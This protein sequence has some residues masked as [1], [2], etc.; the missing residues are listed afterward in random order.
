VFVSFSGLLGPLAFA[1]EEVSD[2][3]KLI[4]SLLDYEN[5]RITDISPDR[6]SF[7]HEHGIASLPIEKVPA[8]IRQQ[9]GLTADDAK[10]Y[11]E[12]I[13]ESER[14]RL[15]RQKIENL[16]K[17]NAVEFRGEIFQILENGVFLKDVSYTD[18]S[19][20]EK[21]ENYQVQTGG[22]NALN[23]N[24]S[25][26]FGTRERRSWETKVTTIR[27]WPIHVRTRSMP[28]IDGNVFSAIVYPIGTFTYETRAGEH[29][30]VPSYTMSLDE[31]L[32]FRGIVREQ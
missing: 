16:L 17:E 23:P 10:A 25:Q 3:N 2:I 29:K 11:R 13:A 19:K 12:Q 28:K 31:F 14:K 22:P 1:A 18:G 4:P 7:T 21:V 5:V 15:A 30:S 20:V 8:E 26:S 27:E 6:I 24:R 32:A 9:V